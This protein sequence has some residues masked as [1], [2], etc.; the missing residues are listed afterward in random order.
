MSYPDPDIRTQ[1]SR[2]IAGQL[3]YLFDPEMDATTK[4]AIIKAT[5]NDGELDPPKGAQVDLSTVH[6]RTLVDFVSKSSKKLFAALGLPDGF[7][8]EDPESW[9]SRDNFKAAE[10]I[11]KS[12]NPSCY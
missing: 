5:N 2:K 7:M 1:A 9:N 6:Q 4:R 11:I 3:W 12:Q 8:A 10:A